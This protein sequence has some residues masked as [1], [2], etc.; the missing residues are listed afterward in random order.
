MTNVFFA[1]STDSRAVATNSQ[2]QRWNGT[3]WEDHDDVNWSTYLITPTTLG[4]SIDRVYSVPADAVRVAIYDGTSPVVGATPVGF[5]ELGTYQPRQNKPAGHHF[6]IEIGSRRDGKH[7]APKPVR[8]RPGAVGPT[9]VSIDMSPVYGNL[10][11]Q[12]VGTPTVSGGSL[13]ATAIAPRDTEAMVSLSGT[14]S[15]HEIIEVTVPVTMETG[16][17]DK[18]TFDVIAFGD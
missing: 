1:H 18:V 12:T 9:S 17:P 14:A 4:T 10:D 13:V 16:E 2:G 8:I 11:V 7:K 5:A 3:A 15:A 6:R